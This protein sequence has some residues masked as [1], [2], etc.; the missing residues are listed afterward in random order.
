MKRRRKAAPTLEDSELL[1]PDLPEAELSELERWH[2]PAF[3]DRLVDVLTSVAAL[4]DARDPD[5][6]ALLNA[7]NP[8]SR[9]AH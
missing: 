6:T 9:R 5:P 3:R 1:L 2:D 8:P 4:A 7:I